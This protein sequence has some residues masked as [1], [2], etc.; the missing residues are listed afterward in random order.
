MDLQLP[1]DLA[2]DGERAAARQLLAEIVADD[3][4][5]ELAWL[6]LAYCARS[7]IER[8]LYLEQA[9]IINPANDRVR[10][11]LEKLDDV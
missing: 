3:P 10:S 5:N 1:I 8:Q 4:Y 7:I 6:W 9:L 2:L 11:E